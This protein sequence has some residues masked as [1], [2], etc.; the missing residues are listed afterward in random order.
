MKKS[1][2]SKFGMLVV[3]G[4][5]A[6]SV[7]LAG[8]PP[9]PPRQGG[10]PQCEEELLLCLEST[11]AFPATGQTTC[12]YFDEV[13]NEFVA[14]PDCDNPLTDGQDGDI[15]AGADL[16]Y[17]DNGLTI[18]DNNTQLEWMKQ[19]D[20]DSLGTGT[21][22]CDPGSYPGNLDKDC[23]FT[24]D[25]A[26]NFV[27]SLNAANHAGG[28]WR[29]PNVKELQSIVNYENFSPPVSAEFDTNCIASCKVDDPENP[30]NVCSC[31]AA[32]DYWSSTSGADFPF[33]AWGV[34]FLNGGVFFGSKFG[35]FR[36][37]AVRGGLRSMI[38]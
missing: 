12:W 29:V 35:D 8:P 23:R 9:D 5:L 14:D 13:E 15:Q 30:E 24:W 31:T 33:N 18:T 7:A 28:G 25:D 36:V 34:G 17:T 3:G 22:S 10:I 4:W 16:S 1:S 11:Q 27:A 38:G 32:T 2:L 37:R 20:N 26:F 6:S 19:D 21:I